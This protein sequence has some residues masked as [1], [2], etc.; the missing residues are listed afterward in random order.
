MNYE[1]LYSEF[2]SLEKEWK[3]K[4]ATVQKL[5]KAVAKELEAGDLKS[6]RR[7][8]AALAQAVSEEQDIL[9]RMG[10]AEAAFDSAAYFESGDFASQLLAACAELGIDTKG[11]YPVYEM[12]PYR[13][14]IDAENQD[15]YLDRKKVSCMR[16]QSFA[17]AVKAGQDRLMKASFNAL[18][19]ASELAD[20]YDLALIRQNKRPDSD[21]YLMSLYRLLTPM[22]RFRRDYDQQSYA[23]DLA[24]LYTS[25]VTQIK[26]GR[27]LQFGPS[28]NNTK[29]IR[30]L[31]SEGK[32]QYL[33]TIRFYTPTEESPDT[34]PQE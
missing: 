21:F 7:D 24:R 18:S 31:D 12:F 9:N 22:S 30:I 14:R 20:A 15:V 27:L 8:R 5:H 17:Q 1:D 16:P 4:S 11:E 10:E 3:D 23:F 6:L 34:E 26:D 25:G 29:A 33:A 28:R 2:Q 32:E 19:F 13:V